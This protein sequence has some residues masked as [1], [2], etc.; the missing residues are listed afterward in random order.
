MLGWREYVRG[1]YWREMPV[2]SK[3]NAL[4]MH[5]PLPAFYWDGDTGDEFAFAMR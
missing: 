1:I 3:R 2:I 5:M 4:R